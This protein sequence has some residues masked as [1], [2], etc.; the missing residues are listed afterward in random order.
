MRPCFLP[1][2]LLLTPVMACTDAGRASTVSSDDRI[3]DSLIDSSDKKCQESADKSFPPEVARQLCSCIAR[4]VQRTLP[5]KD[6]MAFG[7]EMTVAGDD[8]ARNSAILG[9]DV[10][11]QILVTCVNQVIGQK[12]S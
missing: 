7:Q 10:V 5:M 9:N 12:K 11:R 8:K 1:L 3:P 2:L 6:A 4:E